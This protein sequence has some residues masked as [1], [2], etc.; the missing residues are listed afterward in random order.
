MQARSG[1]EVR[2]ATLLLGH[3]TVA[4]NTASNG[5]EGIY[6]LPNGQTT[7]SLG[8]S[9]V[10][11]G[12]TDET[13]CNTP[14]KYAG[15]LVTDP[16]CTGT[17]TALGDIK[18]TGLTDHGG[19]TLTHGLLPGSVA[20]DAISQCDAEFTLDQ[21]GRPRPGTGSSNCDIGAFELQEDDDLDTVFRDRFRHD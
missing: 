4:F 1:S 16:S 13:A 9:L 19:A 14:A 7:L 17:A 8:N 20:I 5:T 11:Q 15:S 2:P 21:R 6:A 12:G 10:V 3:S 18:L